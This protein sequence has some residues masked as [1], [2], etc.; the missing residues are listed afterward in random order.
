MVTPGGEL[1]IIDFESAA[2]VE[3]KIEPDQHA[4]FFFTD[5]RLH[6]RPMVWERL[7]FLYSVVHSLNHREEVGSFDEEKRIIDLDVVL[8]TAP[9][10]EDTAAALAMIRDIVSSEELG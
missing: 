3:A 5:R 4:T 10:T 2:L 1:K 7:H 9:E 8:H 6:A